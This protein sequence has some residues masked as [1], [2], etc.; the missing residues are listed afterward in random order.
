MPREST[1]HFRRSTSFAVLAIKFIG[2]N[3]LKFNEQHYVSI[4]KW[5]QGEYQAL[6]HL[7]ETV[8]DWVT[9]L[10]EIPEETWDFEAGAPSKTLDSHLATFGKRLHAKWRGRHCFIDSCHIEGNQKMED[11]THHIERIFNL[12]RAEGATAIPTIGL[13]RLHGYRAAIKKIIA[14]DKLGVCIRLIPSDF[15]SDL[16][17]NLNGLME[18]IAV[19]PNEVH[20]IIDTSDELNDDAVALG[21]WWIQL[22]LQVPNQSAWATLTIAGS[23]FPQ[24]LPTATYR[25]DGTALRNEWLAYKLV[26]TAAKDRLSRL[27]TFGD[28]VCASPKTAKLDPRQIDPNAKIKYTFGDHWLIALG[29]QVKKNG[30]GQYKNLC[31]AIINHKSKA[32]RGHKYSHGDDYIYTCANG[33]STGGTSTWPCVASNH[34]IT[35]VA[36]DLANLHGALNAPE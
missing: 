25:P 15:T 16:A 7:E 24:S 17:R 10:L 35:M 4:V 1:R 19:T 14:T 11:G 20:L 8:K 5:R 26:S 29:V 23:S 2:S 31:S 27:P 3:M 32:Y 21:N 18:A 6:T 33:G 13:S 28:Y 9:P 34:H 30:R 12:V 22:L 36:R